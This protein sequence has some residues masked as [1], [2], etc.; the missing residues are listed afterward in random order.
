[1]KFFSAMQAARYEARQRQ[2][3]SWKAD[4]NRK[5]NISNKVVGATS[6][7]RFEVLSALVEATP[8][9]HYNLYLVY[10]MQP[11][12]QPVDQPICIV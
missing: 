12:L 4:V 9:D 10:T 11:V 1:M 2:G 5:L 6:S 3:W 8:G 7:Y